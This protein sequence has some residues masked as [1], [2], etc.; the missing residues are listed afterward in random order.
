MF[1]RELSKTLMELIESL[2]PPLE[3]GLIITEAEMDIPL[4]TGSAIYKDRMIF[5][6]DVP[7]SRWNAGFLPP[8]TMSKI[9]VVLDEEV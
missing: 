5:L 7:H 6:G 3:S 2:Q 4:E 1:Q 9:R 8:V